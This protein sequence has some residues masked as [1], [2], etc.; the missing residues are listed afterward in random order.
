MVDTKT[1]DNVPEID[2]VLLEPFS[3]FSPL[4][5]KK[6]AEKTVEAK[7]FWLDFQSEALPNSIVIDKGL[8]NGSM[9][10]GREYT[11]VTVPYTLYTV[12]ASQSIMN[13]N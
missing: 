10:G 2:E 4:L 13:G 8:L 6:E 1:S 11:V 9:K 7:S 5:T 3:P 12:S